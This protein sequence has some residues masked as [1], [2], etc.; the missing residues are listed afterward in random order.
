MLETPLTRSL[1][2]RLSRALAA[3]IILG[4]LVSLSAVSTARADDVDGISGAPADQVGAD[5][6]LRFSYQVGPGQHVDDMY[7]VR[8]TGTTQQTMTVFATDAYNTDDGGYG[9]LNTNDA[10]VD[11]GSWVRFAD[12]STQQ[13]IPLEPGQSQLVPFSVDV[14]ADAAPGDHAAGIVIS[15]MSPE[16]QVMVDRRVATRLYVRV[17]GDLQPSLTMGSIAASYTGKLNPFTGVASITVTLQNNGNIALSGDLVAGVNTYLGIA[18]T[19]PVRLE[20]D[21]LL[22]GSTRTLTF[23]VPGVAQLGYL[24]PYV[25]VQPTV[26]E[27]ALDPGQMSEVSRDTVLVAIPWWLVILIGLALAVWLFL[28]IR[29][30]RDERNAA[31]WIA[32][33]EA[34]ARRKALE[35]KGAADTDAAELV[36]ESR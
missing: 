7:I 30:V 34:E 33:T 1:T 25:R 27:G 3:A 24:N 29:G 20:V 28:R 13:V 26:D 6:R 4:S 36:D 31:E 16:G 14:P 11:A 9:L 23:D 5:G 32:F 10:P 21:E 19:T 12:G 22:P 18:A 2:T 17:P 15:V 35:E 8:N